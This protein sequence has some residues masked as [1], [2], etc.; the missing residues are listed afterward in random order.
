MGIGTTTPQTIISTGSSTNN[1]KL[2]LYDDGTTTT[3]LYGIGYNNTALTFSAGLSQSSNPQMVI[4][5]TGYIGI[6]R[7]DP[8]YTTDILGSLRVQS[9][10][11]SVIL[12]AFPL[13]GE[14]SVWIQY[15]GSGI[16]SDYGIIQ[17][18]HQGT[19]WR[20]L[21]LNPYGASVGIGNFAPAYPLD[22]TGIIRSTTSIYAG[23]SIGVGT[24][25]PAYPL[26]VVGDARIGGN[27]IIGKNIDISGN[28]NIAYNLTVDN[29]I[30]VGNSI[31]IGPRITINEGGGIPTGNYNLYVGTATNKNITGSAYNS[32]FGAFSLVNNTSG[33]NNTGLGYNTLN[34]NSTGSVN[35]AVG[36]NSLSKNTTGIFNTA[37]GGNS[38]INNSTGNFNTAI[39]YNAFNTVTQYNNSTAIGYNSVPTSNNQVILGTASESVYIPG[40]TNSTSTSTGALQVTGGAGVI[41][42]IYVGGNIIIPNNINNKI[43][44]GTTTPQTVLSTG[45]NSNNIKLALYDDGVTTTNLYGIGAINNAITFS[46]GLSQSSNPQMVI[47]N[48]GFVGI[49]QIA[50]AYPLD[51]TGVIRSTTSIYAGT[52]IG[53]GTITPAYALDVTGVIRST[54]SIYAGTSIGIGTITPAYALDVTGS[55]RATGTSYSTY[56]ITTSD[57]RIKVDPKPLGNLYSVDSLNPIQYTNLLSGKKDLGFIAHEVQE[58]FP[59]LVE[60]EKD[61]E[62]YQSLNYTGLIAVLVKEI[63]DLK[64]RVAILEAK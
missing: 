27:I 8:V 5:N 14:R 64:K 18:E 31:Q 23:T 58:V 11:N 54:T 2:A 21:V 7:S 48:T 41:G 37:I 26:D 63:Q 17:A 55:F 51:V 1:I 59:N 20:N 38:L 22:V 32:A 3:N 9:G 60:G 4:K 62:E 39:G 46:A 25:S 6:G 12:N 45:P 35:T 33:N 13:A 43:G 30:I 16:S 29:N 24:T 28:L 42:N 36:G 10:S 34:Q 53:I 61:G 50:P 47:K 57:Y 56:F 49:A 15:I 52:S 19:S 40:T 44:I